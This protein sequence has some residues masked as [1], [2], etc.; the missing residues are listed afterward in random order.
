MEIIGKA[1]ENGLT[2]DRACAVVGLKPRRFRHWRRLAEGGDYNRRRKSAEVRPYNALMSAEKDA[3]AEAVARSA[4]ADLSCRE[5]SV[6]LMEEKGVY[7]SHV[8]IWEYQKERGMA[9][10]RGGR[11]LRGRRRGEKPDVEWVKG[12]GQ[13]WS[14]DITKLH[15]GVK[16]RFWY[17]YVVLDQWSRKVVG[18]LVSERQTSELAQEVWDQALLAEGLKDGPMPRSLS[19]RGGQM[20]SQSTREFF[21]ELGVAQLFS[22]PRTPND[23]AYVESFFGT[24][25]THPEYPGSFETLED[26]RRYFETFFTWYNTVHL[27]TRIGMV[28]PEQKHNGDWRRVQAERERIKA[29]TLAAR[30]TANLQHWDPIKHLKAA[31][32]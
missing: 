27:H 20:R 19:D 2:V 6:R 29:R 7:V 26:A 14:W 10:H 32:S 8:A 28:T 21:Q 3:I 22:R 25:K 11:R 15:L 16:G 12:P 17:L 23:N 18:W 1:R 13:L 5:L 4:W 9:G 24:V 30:R 31:I